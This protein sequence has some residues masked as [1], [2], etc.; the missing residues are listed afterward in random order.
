MVHAR[1]QSGLRVRL[2]TGKGAARAARHAVA[3]LRDALG[4]ELLEDVRLLVTELVTNG[5]RHG[6]P[7]QGNSLW[8]CVKLRGHAVR[9]EV[10]DGGAGFDPDEHRLG[11]GGWGLYLVGQIADRW[12]VMRERGTLA[13]FEIDRGAGR[14]TGG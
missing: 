14:P 10:T 9:V 7:A 3:G 13:W 11:E 1:G 5:V 2:G 12:G 4:A 8:L 6:E